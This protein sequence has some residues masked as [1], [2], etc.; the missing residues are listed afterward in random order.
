[1]IHKRSVGEYETY[2]EIKNQGRALIQILNRLSEIVSPIEAVKETD[3]VLLTGCGSSYFLSQLIAFA[4]SRRFRK[5]WRAVPASELILYPDAYRQAGS[6]LRLISFS[7]SGATSE[8]VLATRR[9]ARDP[10]TVIVAVTCQPDSELQMLAQE[11]IPFPELAEKSVVMTQ[12][13]TGIL[14]VFLAWCGL[15]AEVRQ[16][17]GIIDR[18]LEENE[19]AAAAL[20]RENFGN[21]IFL[22]A[23]PFFPVARESMLK[24]KEMTALCCEAWQSFEFRHGFKA[25]VSQG[26]LVWLFV[27]QRD[28]PFLDDLV[29]ELLVQGATLCLAG[30]NIPQP[31]KGRCHFSFELP[32][33]ALSAEVQAM[34]ALHLAQ[35]YAFYKALSLNR[36]PD[37]PPDVSRVVKFS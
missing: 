35:L 20:S 27:Q 9:M 30:S 18:S 6:R 23:G 3:Q 7:R 26:T 8:T 1:M 29:E 12:A 25:L 33:A 15:S 22:G 36:N 10:S 13:F 5:N 16:A 32:T 11:A 24:V 21:L 34:S 31:L 2:R 17:A 14:G 19:A 28:L 4:C 37:A